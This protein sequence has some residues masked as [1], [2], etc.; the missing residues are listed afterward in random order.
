MIIW[1]ISLSNLLSEECATES[2]TYNKTDIKFRIYNT[3]VHCLG[4]HLCLFESSA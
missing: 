1:R 3:A 4:A 2:C